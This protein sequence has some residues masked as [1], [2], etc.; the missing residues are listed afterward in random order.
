MNQN[1]FFDFSTIEMKKFD[2]KLYLHRI[3][4]QELAVVYARF[5]KGATH[6]NIQHSN[7]EFFYVLSGHIDVDI[8]EENYTLLSEN[9]VLIPGNEFHSMYAQEDSIALISFAPPISEEEASEIKNKMHHKGSRN[10]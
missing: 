10:M 7:E 3:V 9:G 5:E 4:G 1:R 8:G 2:D 6:T